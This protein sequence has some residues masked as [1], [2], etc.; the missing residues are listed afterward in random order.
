[1]I[2]KSLFLFVFSYFL[3]ISC[4]AQTPKITFERTVDDKGVIYESDKGL[5]KFPFQNTGDAPLIISSVKSSCG[6][7]VPYWNKQPVLS[8][9]WDTIYGK[10]DTKRLGPINKSLTVQCNDTSLP[11]SV[12]RIKGEVLPI[13]VN[14]IIVLCVDSTQP[15]T[16]NKYNTISINGSNKDTIVLELKNISSETL[17]IEIRNTEENP[18]FLYTS[19]KQILHSGESKWIT[20]MRNSSEKPLWYS[21]INVFYARK[22]LSIEIKDK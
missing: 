7:L 18:L 5:F 2:M 13:P 10:Y 9:N 4:F 6:C 11:T 17:E 15:L 16:I 14:E 20:L 21:Q 1:M 19:S 12:L 3:A 8:G 22:K